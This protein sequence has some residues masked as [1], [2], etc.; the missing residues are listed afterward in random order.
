MNCKRIIFRVTKINSKQISRTNKKRSNI[1]LLSISSFNSKILKTA[2]LPNDNILALLKFNRRRNISIKNPKEII[3]AGR[4]NSFFAFRT[5]YSQF[6]QGM[7]Q[8]NLSTILA[9]EWKRDEHE[10]KLWTTMTEQYKQI[11]AI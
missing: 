9:K 7:N 5:Y 2:H 10:Q 8:N 4:L 11:K 3:S 6:G 1:P